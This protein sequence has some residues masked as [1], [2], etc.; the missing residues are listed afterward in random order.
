MKDSEF[1]ELLNLYVDHEISTEQAARLEAEVTSNADRRKVYR[2]YCMIQK[3]CSL[4]T[5]SL[6]ESAPVPQRQRETTLSDAQR[7]WKWSGVFATSGLAAAA[8][9]VAL[10]ALHSHTQ[11]VSPAATAP[12]ASIS[13]AP[14]SDVRVALAPA[15]QVNFPAQ[16]GGELPLQTVLNFHTWNNA[17]VETVGLNQGDPLAWTDQV[18]F[19]PLSRDVLDTSA[20]F[21]SMP[22]LV[23]TN[24]EVAPVPPGGQRQ[25]IEDAAFQ[26]KQR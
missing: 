15:R 25:D 20:I 26:F 19:S 9:L 6:V 14:A 12:V 21:K 24:P 8:C 7:F 23:P 18:Q 13:K 10:F 22:L 4:L 16:F 1:L 17:G 3:G 2:Q 5:G 11:M